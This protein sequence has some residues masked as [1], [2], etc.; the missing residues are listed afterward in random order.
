[1]KHIQPLFENITVQWS[2]RIVL[3]DIDG[4][5]APD[6]EHD[7]GSSRKKIEELCDKNTVYICTNSREPE[8]VQLIAE[9]LNL[10]IASI[11]YK[12]PSKKI[13]YDIV[14]NSGREILGREVIVIGD[15]FLTDYL[16]AKR[17]NA[18]FVPVSRK[19]SGHE[20][21]TV[22]IIYLIDNMACALYNTMFRINTREGQ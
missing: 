3:L 1:M 9:K 16:F 22:K 21:W 20:R 5:V 15:K 8:R 17:I 14:Y 6:H 13:L 7:F 18:V 10:P 11:K 4:T 12:K 2:G 19:I